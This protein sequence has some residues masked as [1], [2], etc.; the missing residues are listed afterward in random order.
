MTVTIARFR[1]V[2]KQVAGV[3]DLSDL[4]SWKPDELVE[5]AAT[6]HRGFASTEAVVDMASQPK[7][8]QDQLLKQMAQFNRDLLEYLELDSAIKVGDVGRMEDILPRLL[9]RF[10]GGKNHKYAVEILEL[11]QGLHREWPEDVR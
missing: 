3:E 7:E 8:S 10:T 9:F 6:I 11:L 1:D 4:R 2:W 5:L